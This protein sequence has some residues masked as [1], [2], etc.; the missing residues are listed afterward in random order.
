MHVYSAGVWLGHCRYMYCWT[1]QTAPNSHGL[2][3]IVTVK[4]QSVRILSRD[5][6]AL[7]NATI[8]GPYNE[9]TDIE[10]ECEAAGA[11]PVPQ[12]TWYNG[13]TIINGKSF[14][15]FYF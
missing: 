4:P 10:L 3:T 12:V 6:S 15:L 13:S 7:G 14:A 11:K 5:G 9:G 1:C 8:L 2:I